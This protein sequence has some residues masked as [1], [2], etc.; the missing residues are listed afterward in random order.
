MKNPVEEM[1]ELIIREAAE[2]VSWIDVQEVIYERLNDIQLNM[3]M[4]EFIED[5]YNKVREAK[6][7][8]KFSR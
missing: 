2:D 5:V 6:V 1:A 4:D 3:H 8:V 7:I